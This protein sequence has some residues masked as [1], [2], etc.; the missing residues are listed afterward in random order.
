MNTK[1]LFERDLKVAYL[2]YE[3]DDL[4]E[5][6]KYLDRMLNAVLKD[7]KSLENDPFWSIFSCAVF[8]AVVLNCFY[9]KK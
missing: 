7:D 5:T 9:N 4:Q 3:N 1:E 6:L 8:K 2:N